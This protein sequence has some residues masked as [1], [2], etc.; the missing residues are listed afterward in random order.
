MSMDLKHLL[1]F[2]R[3]IEAIPL[4]Y[5]VSGSIASI[6]YGKPRLTQ[7]MDIV[8]VFSA[9]KI[10]R[11]VASFP[12]ENYYCPPPEAIKEALKH[13]DQGLLNV[14]DQKTGFKIDIYP[15][16]DDPL[17]TWGFENKKKVELIEN[18]EVWVAPPEYV[19]VKKLEYFK[20]GSSQKHLEDIRGMLEVQDDRIDA[21]LVKDWCNKRDLSN[22]W[23]QV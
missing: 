8:V 13:G 23:K 7:D 15:A 21:S 11:F 2:L 10:D 16:S 18:E 6:L 19:I 3:I 17:I 1:T 5:M 14:I 12:I 22:E 20:E 9:D 4:N